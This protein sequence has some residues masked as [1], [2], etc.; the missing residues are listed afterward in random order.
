MIFSIVARLV[1][2]PAP[3]LLHLMAGRFLFVAIAFA[4]LYVVAQSPT[5]LSLQEARKL[6]QTRSPQLTA[7]AVA[8][9]ALWRRKSINLCWNG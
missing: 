5:P 3:P 1:R 6:A 9:T 4:P 7:Q 2:S 8:I